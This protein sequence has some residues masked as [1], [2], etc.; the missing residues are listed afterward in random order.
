MKFPGGDQE[1]EKIIWYAL[2]VEFV[3]KGVWQTLKLQIIDFLGEYQTKI[4]RKLKS[5]THD[6]LMF[7]WWLLFF[8]PVRRCCLEPVKVAIN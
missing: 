2:Y 6:M 7:F 4:S 5:H 8:F 1:K 3:S